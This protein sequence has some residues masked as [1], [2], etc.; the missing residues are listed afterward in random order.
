M[1]GAE[2]QKGRGAGE[3]RCGGEEE[4][5][6]EERE[7]TDVKCPLH[8]SHPRLRGKNKKMSAKG[9]LFDLSGIQ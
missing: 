8:S 3:Q 9:I 2:E 7:S 1:E 5:G 6:A 4:R